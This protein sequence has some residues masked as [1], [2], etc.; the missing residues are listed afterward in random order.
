[1]NLEKN[2]IKII[3]GQGGGLAEEVIY[4][5]SGQSTCEATD[6]I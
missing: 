3:P 1:M 6:Q 2:K 4:A 5:S